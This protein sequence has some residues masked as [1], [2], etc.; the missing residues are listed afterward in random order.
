[1]PIYY[2]DAKCSKLYFG[3]NTVIK[4]V[5]NNHDHYMIIF[6]LLFARIEGCKDNV[7][8]MLRALTFSPSLMGKLGAIQ[9]RNKVS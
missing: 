5:M 4:E 1:M 7:I 8:C 2:Y 3:N 9:G 6:L